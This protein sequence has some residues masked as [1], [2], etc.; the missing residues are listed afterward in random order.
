MIKTVVSI[1]LPVDE[2]LLIKKQVI[3]SLGDDENADQKN[4]G[5]KKIS[6]VTGIHGDELEGQL[7]CFEV[8][9][10]IKEHPEFLNGIVDIYPALN[11]LGLDST[12]RSLPAFD[13]DMNKTFPGF[14]DGTMIEHLAANIMQDLRG[15]DFVVDIHAS[16]IFVREIPQIRIPLKFKDKLIDKCRLMNMDLIWA[17]E[18]PSVTENTLCYALNDEGINAVVVDMGIAMYCTKEHCSQVTEGILNLMKNLGIW[19]GPV[20]E[21]KNSIYAEG[22]D[23][24]SVVISKTPGIFVRE[25][26]C[27][28]KVEKGQLIGRVINPLKGTVEEEVVAPENGLLFTVR[29][30]PVVEVG[31]LLGRIFK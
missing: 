21:I 18:S 25:V 5:V 13:I 8:Q 19:T 6:I 17:S 22:L 30:Y 9:R 3:S 28:Q 20:G 12:T 15:S 4:N 7:V 26:E 10:R 11:P 16:S 14:N 27:G 1:D 2:K 23:S 31:S 29:E 24:T